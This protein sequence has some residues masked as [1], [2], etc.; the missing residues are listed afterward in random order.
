[1]TSVGLRRLTPGGAPA[2]SA[3]IGIDEIR[4]LLPHRWPMLLV[5]RLDVLEPGVRAVA[6]KN[7]SGSE[8]W[9]QGHFPDRS[10][11]PGIIVVEALAQL[12]G[13][14]AGAEER[15]PDVPVPDSPVVSYLTVLRSVRFRR[16]IVPGDQI[17]LTAQRIAGTRTLGEYRVHAAVDGT[18]AVEGSLSIA[19]PP[20]ASAPGPHDRTSIG[21]TAGGPA[22]APRRRR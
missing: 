3:A 4:S 16:P 10:V 20:G 15:P 18:T 2:R 19:E 21:P 6:V 9:F 11:L 8:P 13:I 14:V 7:V 17:V 12:A 1:M 22:G 5:D